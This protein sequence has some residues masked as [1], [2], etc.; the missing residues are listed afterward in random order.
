MKL[1]T[2]QIISLALAVGAVVLFVLAV[3]LPQRHRLDELGGEIREQQEQLRE[4]ND[5]S[6][7][8]V[9]LNQRL[10][11]LRSTVGDFER[12]LPDH[13][14]IGTLL[15]QIVAGLTS[16]NLASQEIRPLSPT[17]K[18]RYSELPVS[19]NFQGSFSN[20]CTFLDKI[21]SM[22]NL[23]QVEELKLDADKKD[24]TLIGA[25]MVLKIY[26]GRS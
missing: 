7:I 21:E 14:R 5:K 16:A 23:N 2:E 1:V 9:P 10:E 12:R 6:T 13:S 3:H 11:G 26:C 22:P 8:L 15:E 19:L 20:I 24:G 17:A 18:P 25:R 4:A